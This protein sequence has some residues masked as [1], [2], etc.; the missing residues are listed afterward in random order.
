MLALLHT[1]WQ[2][3]GTFPSGSFAFSYG[4]EGVAALG[5]VKDKPSLLSLVTTILQWRWA[6]FDRVALLRAFQSHGDVPK[7]ARIDR[8]VEAG[9]FGDAMRS[10]SRR[11]GGSFLAS[12]SALGNEAATA[13]RLSVRR[14]ECFGHISVMQGAVWPTLGM[15]ERMV[16]FASAYMTASGIASAAIRLGVVGAMQA[17]GVIGE[18][19]PL[20]ERLVAHDVPSDAN[21]SSFVPFLDIASARQARASLR[22]FAN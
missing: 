11:N 12:H 15:D 22:L 20:I 7:I 3:D 10:G 19:L 2:A 1:I 16:Q 4:V 14:K 8:D 6:T 5:S 18:V 17:Q 13:L 9:T 21:L